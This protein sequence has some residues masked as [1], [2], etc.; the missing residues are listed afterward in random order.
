MVITNA[1]L[2]YA[3]VW[4]PQSINGSEPKYSVSLVISKNDKKLLAE[5]NAEIEK[6]MVAGINTKFQGKRPATA[7]MPLRDGDIERPDDPIYQN[8]Y[9]LNANSK[10]P[11][12][13]VDRKVKPI[14]D[15]DEIYSGCIANV[16]VSFFAF[17]SNGNKGIAAGL[18]NI[19]KVRDGDRLGGGTTPEMDFK[20]LEDDFLD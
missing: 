16:S 15:Q 5:I 4:E 17:N 2:S 20:P 18:G 10:N 14:F 11:P 1:K 3:H 6:A 12:R 9:F 8:C 7:K 19:Q 13:I